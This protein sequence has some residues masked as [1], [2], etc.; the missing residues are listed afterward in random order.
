MDTATKKIALT[1]A[2]SSSNI[3]C[4]PVEIH[5]SSI[6]P[7]KIGPIAE[8]LKKPSRFGPQLLGAT[9]DIVY[10]DI[11]HRIFA[12]KPNAIFGVLD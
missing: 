11:T 1:K 3:T 5:C 9:F 6:R 12:R 2:I 10:R 4:A 8:V 7:K